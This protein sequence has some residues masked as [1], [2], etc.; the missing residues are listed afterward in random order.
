RSQISACSASPAC[1]NESAFWAASAM[2]L[3]PCVS[4]RWC[5]IAE[6]SVAFISGPFR[7]RSKRQDGLPRQTACKSRAGKGPS[8]IRRVDVPFGL[9]E[10]ASR[11]AEL[12]TEP[13]HRLHSGRVEAHIAKKARFPVEQHFES[14]LGERRRHGAAI[15]HQQR[16]CDVPVFRVEKEAY[17]AVISADEPDE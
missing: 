8:A 15:F 2:A 5:A 1:R 6:I 14:L 16:L 12:R 3:A 11:R 9:G 17:R 10:R 7:V 4:N 13:E